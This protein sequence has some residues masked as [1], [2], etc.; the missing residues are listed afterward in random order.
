VKNVEMCFT[1]IL[2]RATQTQDYIFTQLK[3]LYMQDF[4]HEDFT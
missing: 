4:D 1:V 3:Y 2:I